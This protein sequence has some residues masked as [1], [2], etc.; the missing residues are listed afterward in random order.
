MPQTLNLNLSLASNLQQVR[1]L[2]PLTP[3]I[4]SEHHVRYG[5]RDLHNLTDLGALLADLHGEFTPPSELPLLGPLL[6]FYPSLSVKTFKLSDQ[7]P[8]TF[9][10]LAITLRP[11]EPYTAGVYRRRLTR[12]CAVEEFLVINDLLLS[13]SDRSP[14][15]ETALLRIHW[16]HPLFGL[17]LQVYDDCFRLDGHL[18]PLTR[19]HLHLG[20]P[21]ITTLSRD[22]LNNC[23][24]SGWK[25]LETEL[26]RIFVRGNQAFLQGKP[27]NLVRLREQLSSAQ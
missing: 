21:S 8:N 11:G 5:E 19:D 18:H 3:A 27:L 22:D 16:T 17:N 20:R 15:E 4:L 23:R 2:L 10:G 9:I 6:E 26:G 25:L 1:S 14:E 7:P 24:H 12:S 13:Q